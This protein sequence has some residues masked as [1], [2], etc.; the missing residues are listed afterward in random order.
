MASLKLAPRPADQGT[1]LRFDA[2]IKPLIPLIFAVVLAAS[3][4]PGVV[5]TESMIASFFPTSTAWRYT[6]WWYMPLTLPF[7]PWAFWSALKRSRASI[8]DSA[9]RAI[10]K[11]AGELGK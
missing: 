9:H 10:A 4:W 5:L 8:H 1:L 2:R 7:A 3:V 11:I 6:W